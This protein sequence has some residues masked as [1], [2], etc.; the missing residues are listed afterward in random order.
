MI[1]KIYLHD[2]DKKLAGVCGGLAEALECDSTL[3]RLCFAVA[4]FTPLPI[5][6][7][8]ILAYLVF[9]KKYTFYT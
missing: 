7:F 2:T 3:I 5:V 9:P 8:Y 6:L 4:F 1:K